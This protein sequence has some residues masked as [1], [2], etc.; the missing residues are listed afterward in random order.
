[1]TSH[2]HRLYQAARAATH[3]SVE[4]AIGLNN[5]HHATS[6]T[7]NHPT[8]PETYIGVANLAM[9]D[10]SDDTLYDQVAQALADE[11]PFYLSDTELLAFARGKSRI[12]AV[13][14][15]ISNTK[16]NHA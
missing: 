2:E 1:M 10:I 16:E 7:F 11:V 15:L 12:D 5:T 6:A 3:P 14:K 8:G 4:I 9:D 13:N